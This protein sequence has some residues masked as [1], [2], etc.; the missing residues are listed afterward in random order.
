MLKAAIQQRTL[1]PLGLLHSLP[2]K[3]AIV[4]GTNFVYPGDGHRCPHV[5]SP[6][7]CQL[8]SLVLDSQAIAHNIDPLQESFMRYAILSH[9]RWSYR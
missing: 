8:T 5:L 1:V 3:A 6:G 9:S 7:L 2:F 4:N